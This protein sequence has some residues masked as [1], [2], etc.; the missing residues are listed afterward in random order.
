[1]IMEGIEKGAGREGKGG[2][3]SGEWSRPA[4]DFYRHGENYSCLAGSPGQ[5]LQSR[6][7]GFARYR[8]L[9]KRHVSRAALGLALIG[10]CLWCLGC[11]SRSE[12]TDGKA[13]YLRGASGSGAFVAKAAVHPAPGLPA[14]RELEAA[15]VADDPYPQDP[16][17][18]SLPLP[19]KDAVEEMEDPVLDDFRSIVDNEQRKARFFAFLRPLV[20]TENR[21]LEA[22]RQALQRLHEKFRRVGGLNATELA[23]LQE[24][25][26][27]YRLGDLP[28]PSEEV[29]RLL[30]QRIDSLPVELVLSQAA[31]ESGWGCSRFAR[32][33]FNLFGEWCFEAGCGLVPMRREAG[34]THE[35]AVFDSPRRSVQSYM[36]NLN[37]HPAYQGLR[38]LRTEKRLQ[39]ERA[40]G[41]TLAAGLMGY[42]E[43]GQEYVDRLCLIMRHNQELMA[44]GGQGVAL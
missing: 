7:D 42:S 43:M 23:W 11:G 6:G 19:G 39:G 9:L 18:S 29:F 27:E 2:V 35:V 21:R 22:E 34:A 12:G 41:F 14:S 38:L 25:A 44:G 5:P 30:L 37:A 33:G 1:M 36:R 8:G 10:A 13:Y 24:R 31:F 17:I 40:D 16:A 20:E 32:E 15:E 3:A 4:A 26:A 28:I